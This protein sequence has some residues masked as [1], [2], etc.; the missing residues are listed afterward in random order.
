MNTITS[1]EELPFAQGIVEDVTCKSRNDSKRK[2]IMSN[3]RLRAKHPLRA[4]P[5]VRISKLSQLVMIPFDDAK[6][7][8]YTEEE[9]RLFN[10]ARLSDSIRVADILWDETQI[11]KDFLYKCVGIENFLSPCTLRRVVQKRRAHSELVLL[12]QRIHQGDN[13]IEKLSDTSEKSSRWACERAART[14]AG[15]AMCLHY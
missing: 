5:Q 6:T 7:K 3:A 8:W 13:R 4:K 9:M 14:A 1:K 15:Y 11:S 2:G 12:A 10:E